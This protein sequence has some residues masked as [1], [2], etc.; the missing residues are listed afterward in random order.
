MLNVRTIAVAALA[1]AALG[2]NAF[3]AGRHDDK[4]HGMPAKSTE[5][6]QPAPGAIPLKDGG[7]LIIG[8]DNVTYHMDRA[9]KRV[10]MRDGQ[11]MEGVDGTKYLMKNDALWRTITEKGTLHPSHQ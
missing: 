8:K 6:V 10:R 5:A 11:V 4:P 3:A 2:F 7:S 9:G 1:V